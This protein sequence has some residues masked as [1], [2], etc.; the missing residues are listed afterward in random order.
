MSQ[1]SWIEVTEEESGQRL[2]NF[3]LKHLRKVP[4]TLIYRVIR[5][6]EVRVNKGRAQPSQRVL[7]GDVVRVPPIMVPEVG[8]TVKPPRAQMDK[9]AELVLY[10]DTDLIIINKPSGI[11]VHG[12]SGVSWGLI[13]LVRELRSDARR[14]EL[15]H[16]LDR[17]TSG[18]IIL[19]KKTSVL[20][21]LHEQVRDNKV[22]K[23]YLTLL[24]GQWPKGKEKVDLPLL[25][26]TL[27][28]GERMVQV[29]D[30]GKPCLSYFM[31]QKQFKNAALMKVRLI[32]GRTH[33]IRVHAQ[34][35]GCPVIGDEKYGDEAA[36][37]YFKQLGMRRLALHAQF[38]Q[39]IHPVTGQVV[40]VEAP[41]FNDFEQTIKLL[42]EQGLSV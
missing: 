42:N 26:N 1:V 23:H 22:E 6:G 30:E 21:A 31:L 33:Q 7:T 29:S 15:V 17:D 40:Q 12:G 35:T 37:K 34:A 20:R 13:E 5:K 32:T 28:S 25:K 3:L 4:K 9:I 18:A 36:N 16:R 41:L 10:E 8:D 27:Q 39:F 14:V 24:S 19:A 38:L 11:A 2:D